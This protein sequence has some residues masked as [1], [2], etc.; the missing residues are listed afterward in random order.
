[1]KDNAEINATQIKKTTRE[2]KLNL[3]L[4]QK[5]K[6]T[7]YFLK[8][9]FAYVA[10]PSTTTPRILGHLEKTQGQKNKKN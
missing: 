7:R 1:M 5:D 10:N 3:K 6:I 9:G 4:L 2:G 8:L